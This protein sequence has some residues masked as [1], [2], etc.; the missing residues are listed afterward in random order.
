[1]SRQALLTSVIVALAY[2][3]PT[4][5]QTQASA[6]GAPA[7]PTAVRDPATLAALDR[8]GEALRNLSEMNIQTQFTAEDVL[9]SGQKLQFGGSIDLVARRPNMLHVSLKM[10]NA[11]R[12]IYYDGKNVTLA[13]PSQGIYATA[14]EAGTIKDVVQQAS[15]KLGLEIPL[16]DLFM[17]GE[18]PALNSRILSAFPVGKEN[19]G[20]Q[21]CDHYAVRQKDVDWQIW[22]RQGAT[23]LPCKMVVTMT[24]DPAMPEFSAIYNW[25]TTAAPP[26]GAAYAYAPPAGHKTIMFET[27][28]PA[29]AAKGKSK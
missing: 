29:P 12:E 3:T 28:L 11:D 20:D 22:I 18:D 24:G 7:A 6:P 16:A 25:S 17:F 8:M 9:N 14:A 15:A 23:A 2:A 10:G 19:V 27:A 21:I 4:I 5:A 26:A 1:M 13:A